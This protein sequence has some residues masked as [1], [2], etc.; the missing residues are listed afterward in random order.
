ML[1]GVCLLS[2][3]FLSCA[4][5]GHVLAGSISD[6]QKEKEELKGQL[7]E[8]QDM[9]REL[10]SSKEDIQEKITQLDV[11]LTEISQRIVELNE[12]LS[13]KES[14]ITDTQQELL[15]ATEDEKQQ[16]ERM[17]KRIRFMY[18]NRTVSFLDTLLASQGIGEFLNRTEYIY[19][20]SKYDRKILFQ[21]LAVIFG[22][23]LSNLQI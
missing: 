17:K 1:R 8:V 10:R 21:H 20:I 15:E 11:R 18:E 2:V 9:I 3:V 6:A 19:Q 4:G 7:N 22:V 23:Y 12:Q 13:Q 16:F 14:E 5:A